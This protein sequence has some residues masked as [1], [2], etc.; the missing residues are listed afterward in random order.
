[1]TP[2]PPDTAVFNFPKT[3]ISCGS[4]LYSKFMYTQR[5]GYTMWCAG[6]LLRKAIDPAAMLMNNLYLWPYLIKMCPDTISTKA[7]RP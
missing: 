4:L 1:M 2:S 7:D 3:A 5:T 6:R